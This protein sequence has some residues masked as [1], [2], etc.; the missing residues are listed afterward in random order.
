MTARDYLYKKDDFLFY[1]GLWLDKYV[2]YC[3][4]IDIAGNTYLA[5]T[6]LGRK[7]YN[8]FFVNKV[9]FSNEKYSKIEILLNKI[10]S[11][12]KLSALVLAVLLD[13]SE[14]EI[15][16]IANRKLNDEETWAVLN[17]L[18]CKNTAKYQSPNFKKIQLPITV[19]KTFQ[20]TSSYILDCYDDYKKIYD[21]VSGKEY[22]VIP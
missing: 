15:K 16:H 2:H 9:T 18:L 10:Q 3:E 14:E 22:A 13:K 1:V 20:K 8:D 4:C 6:E 17:T 21:A 12:K 19:N 7:I 5:T 11:P